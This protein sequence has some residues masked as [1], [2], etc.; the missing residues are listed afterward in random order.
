MN[1]YKPDKWV[2]LKFK[3]DEEISYKVFGSWAGGYVEGFSWRLSSGLE[4]IEDASEYW[5]MHNHSGSVYE[6]RKGTE[7]TYYAGAV[8]IE[9]MKEQAKEQGVAVEQ[10][11]VEQFMEETKR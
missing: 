11:S 2:I 9:S 8:V 7:G 1:T 5:K 6:C 3:D 4:R 10:I